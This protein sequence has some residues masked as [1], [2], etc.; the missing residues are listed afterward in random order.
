MI[1]VDSSF[2]VGLVFPRDNRHG[3]AVEAQRAFANEWLVTSN[4]VRGETWTVLRR[5]VGHQV[6]TRALD[7]LASAPRLRIELISPELESDA[8][9]WLRRHDERPYSFVD[10]TSFA[11]MRRLRIR[12]AL[13]FDGDFTAAGFVELR[14][15]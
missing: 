10:A 12:E 4:H 15:S 6:A 14:G 8:L 7:L 5:R 13:A 3:D 2:W 9:R 1:F 11:L